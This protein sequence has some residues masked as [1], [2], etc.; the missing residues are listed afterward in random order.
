MEKYSQPL[1]DFIDW[2]TTPQKKIK[3]TNE[4]VDYYRYFDATHLAQY[5]YACVTDTITH[6]IPE[7]IS[8]LQQYDAFK[9]RVEEE[10]GLA[11]NDTKLLWTLLLQNEGTISKKKRTKFFSSLSDEEVDRL[12]TI[13]SETG[14][15]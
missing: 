11:D 9:D 5:L 7:E 2:E 10:L 12:E 13:Y 4:T 1:L 6:K 14:E 3:I 15:E 8:L